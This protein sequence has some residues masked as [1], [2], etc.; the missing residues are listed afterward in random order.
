MLKIIKIQS[1]RGECAVVYPGTHMRGHSDRYNQTRACN[2]TCTI[3]YR[4]V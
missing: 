4:H 3:A 1:E 2:I